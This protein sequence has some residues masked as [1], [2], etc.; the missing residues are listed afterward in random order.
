MCLTSSEEL[1]LCPDGSHVSHTSSHPKHAVQTGIKNNNRE[2]SVDI[3][4]HSLRQNEKEEYLLA[5]H[6]CTHS[7]KKYILPSCSPYASSCEM[8]ASNKR[9]TFGR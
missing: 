5:I 1:L 2:M 9:R 6:S 8:A 7:Y 3:K 4:F